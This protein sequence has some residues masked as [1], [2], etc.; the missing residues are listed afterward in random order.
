MDLV[1][2]VDGRELAAQWQF[3]VSHFLVLEP[4]WP[5][6]EENRQRVL[7]WIWAHSLGDAF[8]KVTVL[9]LAFSELKSAGEILTESG[10]GTWTH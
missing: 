1:E 6:G 3:A 4:D 8:D 9:R 7:D 5:G 2:F 10:D